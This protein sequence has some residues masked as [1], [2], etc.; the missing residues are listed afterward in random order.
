MSESVHS[1]AH[2]TRKVPPHTL[3]EGAR[4]QCVRERL[5]IQREALRQFTEQKARMTGLPRSP[6]RAS[7]WSGVAC[8]VKS[9]AGV[10]AGNIF[11]RESLFGL[12]FRTI[13][14]YG[15]LVSQISLDI[16]PRSQRLVNRTKI[17]DH[18]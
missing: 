8:K 5:P 13:V 18:Q 7:A 2:A 17:C 4:S 6:L 11:D 10:P 1:A 3:G 14:H 12:C 16:D 9:S 15:D